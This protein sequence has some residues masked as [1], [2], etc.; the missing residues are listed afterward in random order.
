MTVPTH[1]LVTAGRR[2]LVLTGLLLACACAH[3]QGIEHPAPDVRA[4]DTLETVAG[5]LD[6]A[7]LIVEHRPAPADLAGCLAQTAGVSVA[8]AAAATMRTAADR[9]Q[10]GPLEVDIGPCL[11]ML[12]PDLTSGQDV[13]PFDAAIVDLVVVAR[14]LLAWAPLSCE[15]SAWTDASLA[16]VAGA[17]EP[18]LEEVRA[19][20]GVLVVPAVPLTLNTCGGAP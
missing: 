15:A 18:V 4:P 19:P 12:P 13:P 5:V 2:F 10:I 20:D 14:A 8:R 1:T 7:A 11:P 6:A 17:L 3:P 16:F 9:D